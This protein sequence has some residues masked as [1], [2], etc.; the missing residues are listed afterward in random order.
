VWGVVG[1]VLVV[2]DPKEL[3]GEI[4]KEEGDASWNPLAQNTERDIKGGFQANL[5][6]SLVVTPESED[7]SKWRWWVLITKLKVS[8]NC[9][10]TKHLLSSLTFL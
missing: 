8:S 3:S 7:T 4:E 10:H 2:H 9:I 6:Q 1:E 5:Q